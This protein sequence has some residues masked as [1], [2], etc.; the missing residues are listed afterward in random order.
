MTCDWSTVLGSVVAASTYT[1]ASG[2]S[3]T[4]ARTRTIPP[5]PP[6]LLQVLRDLRLNGS[7]ALYLGDEDIHLN[8]RRQSTGAQVPQVPTQGAP[9]RRSSARQHSTCAMDHYGLQFYKC[10]RRR[11]ELLA[12]KLDTSG[13]IQV[14]ACI[15]TLSITK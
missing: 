11:F 8:H 3:E 7:P 13:S 10:F 1:L 5:V 14:A 12:T 9:A 15:Y 4:V 6:P 2:K